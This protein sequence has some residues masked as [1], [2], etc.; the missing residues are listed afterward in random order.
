MDLNKFTEKSQAALA[1]AQNLATRSQH[2]AV[3]VE[4]LALAMME[5]I[6]RKFVE[7]RQDLFQA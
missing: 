5:S 1:E 6:G 3:D 2:L 7:W 4:H